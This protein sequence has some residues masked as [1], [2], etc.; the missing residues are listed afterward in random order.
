MGSETLISAG[1]LRSALSLSVCA[2]DR[3]GDGQVDQWTRGQKDRYT[4]EEVASLDSLSLDS[5]RPGEALKRGAYR[6]RNYRD[7]SQITSLGVGREKKKQPCPSSQGGQFSEGC[8]R[9]PGCGSADV[10]F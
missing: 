1:C 3:Q 7:R 4:D 5:R 6:S 9:E 2:M 8:D 10:S